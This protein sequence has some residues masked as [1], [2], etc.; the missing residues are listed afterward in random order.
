[1]NPVDP[2]LA[3]AAQGLQARFGDHVEV[4]GGFVR[5]GADGLRTL[6]E[7]RRQGE[8]LPRAACLGDPRLPGG[9]TGRAS[10]W[11]PRSGKL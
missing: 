3:K 5:L 10:T 9:M 2:A 8:E 4:A 11:V 7:D 1:V 6:T